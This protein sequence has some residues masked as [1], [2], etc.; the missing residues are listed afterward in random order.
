M[1]IFVQYWYKN[2]PSAVLALAI[3]FCYLNLSNLCNTGVEFY[4][5]IY[6]KFYEFS[7]K[8]AFQ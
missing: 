5:L 6:W 2:R 3:Y 4:Y 1:L 7:V 8:N